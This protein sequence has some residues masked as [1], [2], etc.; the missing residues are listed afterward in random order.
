VEG[1]GRRLREL[2][3]GK[4]PLLRYM[5]KPLDESSKDARV[6]TF[7]IF[8]HLYDP[9]GETFVTKGPGAL[10]THHRAGIFYGFNKVTY[11][12]KKSCDVWH[13]TGGRLSSP[14]E[15]PAL[16]GGPGLRAGIGFRWPGTAWQGSLRA[17][18]AR[19]D[20]LFA[21]QRDDG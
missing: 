4:R 16:R 17:G 20:G 3:L 10:F 6:Q 12:E 1:H 15:V 13:C 21:A 14:R 7:K 2:S 9:K 8:H 19:P 5:Y 18:R 11:G